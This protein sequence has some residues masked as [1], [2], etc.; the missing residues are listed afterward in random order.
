MRASSSN[1]LTK[2]SLAKSCKRLIVDSLSLLLMILEIFFLNDIP[3]TDLLI[4]LT[5]SGAA[6]TVAASVGVAEFGDFNDGWF[7][8]RANDQLSN[9]FQRL[10]FYFMGVLI[11]NVYKDFA[12]I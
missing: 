10:N 6:K 2:S 4:L 3:I 9:A 12:A 1:G 5:L 11:E 8:N 7:E